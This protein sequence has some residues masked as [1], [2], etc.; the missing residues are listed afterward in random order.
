MAR[1]LGFTL[2]EYAGYTLFGQP[3]HYELTVHIYPRRGTHGIGLHPHTFT[4]TLP[5]AQLAYQAVAWTALRRLAHTYTSRLNGSAFRLFPRLPSSPTDTHYPC[6]Y[7]ESHP[8]LTRLV[9][10]SD[11]QA[12]QLDLLLEAYRALARHSAALEH[13]LTEEGVTSVDTT[14]WDSGRLCHSL[15][16]SFYNSH[17]S[18]DTPSETCTPS[19]CVPYSPYF[20]P[21]PRRR[22]PPYTPGYS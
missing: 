9:E 17:G 20:S 16:Q 15:A 3:P 12:T 10:L 7:C 11:A 22:S 21:C 5:T 14:S 19:S 13:R 1:F 6:P 8:A 4:K 2:P 18:A